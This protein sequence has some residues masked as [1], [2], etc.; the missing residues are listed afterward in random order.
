MNENTPYKYTCVTCK[1]GFDKLAHNVWYMDTVR[2]LCVNLIMILIIIFAFTKSTTAG[3]NLIGL[4]AIGWGFFLLSKFLF[5]KKVCPH[6]KS[7]H[8][9]KNR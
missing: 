1:R 2:A 4:Y 7:E 8:F 9:V 5:G 6:C 3:F